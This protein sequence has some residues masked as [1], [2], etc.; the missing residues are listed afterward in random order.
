MKINRNSLP[1]LDIIVKK[2]VKSVFLI[3]FFFWLNILQLCMQEIYI[4]HVKH[5]WL[6]IDRT[7]TC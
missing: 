1:F 5:V 2:E 3:V 4:I 7:N 6:A